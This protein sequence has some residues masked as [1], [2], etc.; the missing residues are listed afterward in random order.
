MAPGPPWVSAIATPAT[1]PIPTVPDRAVH[2][3][4]NALVRQVLFRHRAYPLKGQLHDRNILK[5]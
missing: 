5:V 4:G 2:K 3:L 1:L